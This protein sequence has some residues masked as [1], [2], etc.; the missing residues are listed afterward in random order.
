MDRSST[1]LDLD[2]VARNAAA[3]TAV[4]HGAL[5][6]APV[7]LAA[8]GAQSLMRATADHDLELPP[9]TS[10]VLRLAVLGIRY[11]YVFPPLFLLEIPFD[12]WLLYR[13]GQRQGLHAKA[14]RRVWS[15]L[16]VMLPLVLSGFVVIAYLL[17]VLTIIGKE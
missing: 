12:G 17:P 6:A 10:L 7:V 14:A 9:F 1:N 5:W 8:M 13:L 15:V 16:M 2:R 11:W 4:L 3:I